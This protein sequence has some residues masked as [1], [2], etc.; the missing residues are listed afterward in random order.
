MSADQR[1]M[2]VGTSQGELIIAGEVWQEGFEQ[3]DYKV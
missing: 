1:F 3:E 2:L